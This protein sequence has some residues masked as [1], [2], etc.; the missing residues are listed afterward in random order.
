[1][2]QPPSLPVLP[3][4]AAAPG[5]WALG[6]WVPRGNGSRPAV[7]CPWCLAL[8]PGAPSPRVPLTL[9]SNTAEGLLTP[10]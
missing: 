3:S 6:G 5:S 1:M 9:P 4:P 10:T 8:I 2:G 7:S